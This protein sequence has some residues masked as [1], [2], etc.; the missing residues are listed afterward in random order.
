MSW[1]SPEQ[2]AGLVGSTVRIATFVEFRFRSAP[3]YVWSGS[4]RARIDG[5][6]W[7]PISVFGPISGLDTPREATSEPVTFTLSGVDQRVAALAVAERSE[8]SGRPVAVVQRLFD[9]HLQPVGSALPLWHGLMQRLRIERT[10]GDNPQRTVSVEAEG[11]WDSRSRQPAGRYNDGDQN[12]R[13]P[14]DRFFRFVGK[15]QSRPQ[16]WPD[17]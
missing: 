6:V 1:I 5:V 9:D 11:V 16:V 7:D 13:F 15:Q 10:D 3:M 8:V 2:A 14:G 4:Y 17:F 12:Y